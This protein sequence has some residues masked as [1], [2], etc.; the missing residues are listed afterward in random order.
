MQ[1]LFQQITQSVLFLYG[2]QK[3]SVSVMTLTFCHK[4]IK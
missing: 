4:E 1:A 2:G 3:V